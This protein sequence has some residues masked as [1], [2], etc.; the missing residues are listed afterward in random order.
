MKKPVVLIYGIDDILR[1]NLKSRLIHYEFRV[2]ES[3][4][5]ADPSE[6][7][8][9]ALPELI[10]VSSYR[11]A[12]EKGLKAI[13]RIRHLDR[14]IPIILIAGRS[15]EAKAIAAIKAGVN[16]YF[17]LPFSCEAVAKSARR[18]LA[19]ISHGTIF[20]EV[21][22]RESSTIDN[23]IIGASTSRNRYRKRTRSKSNPL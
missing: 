22:K 13:K 18:I 15:S 6:Q 21:L 11:K 17:K 1:Q 2:I 19:T 9:T 8:R 16:D 20:N 5:Q 14:N 10:I 7:M 4:E 23:Y 12:F 3:S